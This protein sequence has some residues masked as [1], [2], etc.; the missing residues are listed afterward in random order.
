MAANLEIMAG[1][2]AIVYDHVLEP[3]QQSH[4]WERSN[5]LAA[6]HTEYGNV[7]KSLAKNRKQLI[8]NIENAVD[9]C[10]KTD[11][12][13]VIQEESI[14]PKIYNAKQI[15]LTENGIKA[16]ETEIKTNTPH[17]YKALWTIKNIHRIAFPHSVKDVPDE[18]LPMFIGSRLNDDM[19]EMAAIEFQKSLVVID[20]WLER[21]EISKKIKVALSQFEKKNSAFLKSHKKLLEHLYLVKKLT[22]D[23]DYIYMDDLKYPTTNGLIY[24]AI[25]ALR[26]LDTTTASLP[27][28]TH[29]TTAAITVLKEWGKTKKPVKT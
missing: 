28:L 6:R 8:L 15:T 1:I 13:L 29:R 9:S 24:D 21:E 18:Q 27:D 19:L 11:E 12:R 26:T 20:D 5:A 3:L 22:Y 7:I 25:W 2:E 23:K 17:V 14:G 16:D 10:E 4:I